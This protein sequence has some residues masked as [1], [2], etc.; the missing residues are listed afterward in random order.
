M[1]TRIKTA[2]NPPAKRKRYCAFKPLNSTVRPTPLLISQ[3]A[4]FYRKKERK[5]VA[6]TM[7]KIHAPN[8]EAAVLLVSGSPL[9]NLL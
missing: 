8:Q 7:R 2:S 1:T 9:E 3:L 4:I 6:A 5:I